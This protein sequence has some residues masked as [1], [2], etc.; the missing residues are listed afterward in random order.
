ME[1]KLILTSCSIAI[2]E[3]I[4]DGSIVED[5]CISLLQLLRHLRLRGQWGAVVGSILFLLFVELVDGMN[6]S[7]ASHPPFV[8]SS[9]WLIGSAAQAA[10]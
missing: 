8:I 9:H 5:R 3:R 6:M 10:P 2:G 1:G 4:E 7:R